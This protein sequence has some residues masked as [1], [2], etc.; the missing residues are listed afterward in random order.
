[1]VSWD[2][3][4]GTVTFRNV[5]DHLTVGVGTPGSGRPTVVDPE[6]EVAL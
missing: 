1:M 6:V 4:N 3:R 2:S 5:S